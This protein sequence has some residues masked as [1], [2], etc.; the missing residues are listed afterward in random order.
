VDAE[1]DHSFL[2]VVNTGFADTFFHPNFNQPNSGPSAGELNRLGPVDY[3]Y[4]HQATDLARSADPILSHSTTPAGDP[5]TV[6]LF[7]SHV[8]TPTGG[9]TASAR[10]A[11]NGVASDP[12]F[13]RDNYELVKTPSKFIFAAFKV[14]ACLQGPCRIF[15]RPD[16]LRQ[17]VEIS[18]P[19]PL[20]I[21]STVGIISPIQGGGAAIVSETGS[22]PLTGAVSPETLQ[23][24]FDPAKVFLTPV[25]S[26]TRLVTGSGDR[27]Q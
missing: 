10:D 15:F 12:G 14:F 6:G 23:V 20:Q 16:L 1:R 13:L 26:G 5:I 3:V 8:L 11:G 21:A 25:E 9:P 4:W 17:P 24:M 19:G 18:D 22:V 27:L 7:W 2:A